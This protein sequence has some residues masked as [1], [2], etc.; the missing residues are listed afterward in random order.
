MARMTM[1]VGI[2]LNLISSNRTKTEKNPEKGLRT[3]SSAAAGIVFGLL[4]SVIA[5]LFLAY[6]I[7]RIHAMSIAIR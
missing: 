1:P 2:T 5:W 3:D 4:C 6:G 7:Y